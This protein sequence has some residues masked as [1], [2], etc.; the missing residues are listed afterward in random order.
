MSGSSGVAV[1]TISTIVFFAVVVT[2]FLLA[3]GS[4][5]VRHDFF[6]LAD[7]RQAFVG[8]PKEGIFS[9][10]KAF[11]LNIEIFMISEVLIL[12]F[13]LLIAV[14]RI[15]RSPVLYPL[16]LVAT[17]YCDVFRGIPVLLVI[18]L[19]GFG[20]PA[21]N[22][23]VISTQSLAVYGIITLT[24]T[25]SAYVSEVFRAGIYAVN[26]SQEA[27]A[28]SLGLSCPG[29][30]PRRAAPG[31]PPRDPAAAERLHQPAEGHGARLGHRRHRGRAGGGDL[32]RRAF[33]F[34]TYVV[35]ACLFLLI[36]IPLTRFTDHYRPRPRE[37]P[38]RWRN[39]GGGVSLGGGG[40]TPGVADPAAAVRLEGLRKWFGANE[41][42]E[43]I[44]LAVDEPRGRLPDRRLRL[45]QVDAA[46]L[47]QPPGADRR[48]RD[49]AVGEDI[50]AEGDRADLS[51][52]TSGS[53]S[54]R[55]TSSRT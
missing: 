35:A 24:A 12:F 30:A 28:R 44:D 40:G 15:Q 5:V 29:P 20:F 18:L 16:R 17:A 50:T 51:G 21:L 19:V 13:G 7:M 6:N 49:R 48:G 2:V 43:G 25:Y 9:V 10:G 23:K 32:L 1:S 37:A 46:A 8:D 41:V 31:D 26:P 3:P 53:S 4:A 22:L 47:R 54:S 36:T 55:T 27:A 14:V 39:D 52:A 34:S 42:L 38:R 11:L 45:G 33:N